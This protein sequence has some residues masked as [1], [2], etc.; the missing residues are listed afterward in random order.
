MFLLHSALHE[1]HGVFFFENKPL[2]WLFKWVYIHA[3]RCKEAQY[4]LTIFYVPAFHIR[5]NRR[6][7]KCNADYNGLNYGSIDGRHVP[8]GFV[9]VVCGMMIYI[10]RLVISF[11]KTKSDFVW[12]MSKHFQLC[13]E[14]RLDSNIRLFHWPLGDASIIFNWWFSK[15]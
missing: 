12:R 11:A 8:G 13:R 4:I 3:C 10:M 5:R 6:T 9:F 1:G 7:L 2:N 14:K 15:F